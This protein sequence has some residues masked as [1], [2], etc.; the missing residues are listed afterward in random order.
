VQRLTERKLGNL[1]PWAWGPD[2]LQLLAPLFERLSASAKAALPKFGP[3]IDQLYSKA[4]S[5]AFLGNLLAAASERE[6]QRE[7][8]CRPDVVGIATTRFDETLAAVE[9]IR[10]RG[11]HRVVIKEALG[12]A[13]RNALRLWEP[14]ILETQRQWIQ[15]AFDR[16]GRLVVEPWLERECDFSIQLE[17]GLDG[18]QVRGYTGLMTDLRG[19]FVGNFASPNFARRLPSSVVARFGQPGDMAGALGRFYEEE[20]FRPLET[21]LRE[22]GYLGPL[23][24]D[25]FLYRGPDARVRLKPIVEI[26]PRYTMGRLTVEL[27]Q[28]VGP[29]SHG[30]LLFLNRRNVHRAGSA[31]FVEYARR[32]RE[33]FPRQL[34]GAPVGRLIEGGI[35]LNDPAKAIA[36]LAV[37]L[38]ARNAERLG[39]LDAG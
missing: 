18:L 22:A 14:S 5:A 38:V 23:G 29:G 1:R 7:W 8:L 11:H 39:D 16:G 20:V 15:K 27:M 32:L 13:G 34:A 36:C 37:F 17:M 33:R 4:W 26:N 3:P 6:H 2:S 12:L 9:R 31:D 10:Q 28:R 30:R 25:A 19:Q 35:C 21:A 24:L